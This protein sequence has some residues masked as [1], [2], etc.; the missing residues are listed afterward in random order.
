MNQTT[1][2]T[3]PGGRDSP[4]SGGMLWAAT[5]VLTSA[6]FLAV[7]NTTISNVSVHTIAGG[8]GATTTQG[9]WVIT[10]FSVAEAITVPL[11]GWLAARS[12]VV[13]VFV[14]CLA[15][16]G[17]F[18]AL[19]G[20]STSIDMLVFA[21]VC[22]GFAGGPMMPLSQTLMLRIF[23]KEKSATAIGLWSITTLVA[24]VVG[25]ILG[26]H[27]CDEYSWPWIFFINT[28]IGIACAFMA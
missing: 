9:T 3:S 1:S 14:I 17:A 25:P 4:L 12:G 24:P 26:G 27:L 5:L 21:R 28:P 18:S 2:S 10:S 16:F 6:N 20:F 7:L 11:T 22:Q 15:L 19:C 13:H 23:P 8:L